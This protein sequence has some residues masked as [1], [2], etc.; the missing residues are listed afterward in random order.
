MSGTKPKGGDTSSFS[1]RLLA[2]PPVVLHARYTAGDVTENRPFANL[3]EVWVDSTRRAAALRATGT[4]PV[5]I[6]GNGSDFEKMKAFLSALPRTVGS[7]LHADARADARLLG[8]E[9]AFLSDDAEELWTKTSAALSAG[10][11]TPRRVLSGNKVSFISCRPQE[12]ACLPLPEGCLPLFEADALLEVGTDSFLPY[13]RAVESATGLPIANLAE[14]EAALSVLLTRFATSHAPAVTVSLAH[15][16]AFVKPNPYHAA[17]YFEKAISGKRHA[18][19]EPEAALLRTQLVRLLATLCACHGLR[20]IC[21]FT[22]KNDAR[23]GG[24]SVSALAELLDYLREWDVLCPT[25]LVFPA[26]T[27]PQTLS[28]LLDRFQT[29]EGTPLLFVGLA[30]AGALPHDVRR[31]IRTLLSAGKAPLFLGMCDDDAGLLA[32][33]ARVRFATALADVLAEWVRDGIGF[34][35][36]AL[37]FEAARSVWSEAMMCFLFP[38]QK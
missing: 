16:G 7:T 28:A 5:L 38:Q 14:L 4:D 20:L 35:E 2:I 12:S 23:F 24:Y 36:D 34:G 37:L 33:P 9:G 18:L 31:A 22:S 26:A 17:Q 3:A 25:L 10:E 15:Y 27:L 32:S 8:A 21:R 6:S 1:A 19:S 30:A 29:T 11:F 13:V